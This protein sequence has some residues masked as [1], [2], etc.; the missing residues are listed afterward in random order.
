MKK[1]MKN[2]KINELE[3]ELEEAQKHLIRMQRH[4]QMHLQQRQEEQLRMRPGSANHYANGG[5]R[6]RLSSANPRAP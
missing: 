3:I 1:K 5:K 6:S 2:T 4:M